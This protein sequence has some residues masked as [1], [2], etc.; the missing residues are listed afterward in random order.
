MEEV[1]HFRAHT[2]T[3]NAGH[4]QS[5]GYKSEYS[6]NMKNMLRYI[7]S[8][9]S[10]SNDHGN[11]HQG[12]VE[13][14]FHPFDNNPANYNSY[15]CTTQGYTKEFDKRRSIATTGGDGEQ[16]YHEEHDSCTVI[17]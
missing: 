14:F 12:I 9:V 8:D 15:D 2:G 10:C 11:F 6:G 17:H 4:H 7:E 13:Y 5:Q 1:L 3:P 16:E